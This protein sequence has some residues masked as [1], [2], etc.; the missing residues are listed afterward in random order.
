MTRGRQTNE[1]F[2]YQPVT[3]E[4]DHQHTPPITDP[5][6]HLL[7]RGNTY[8]AAHHFRHILGHDDRPRTLPDHAQRTPPEHLPAEVADLLSRNA[9]RRT[10][11][12]EVWR[13][14]S[15]GPGRSAPATSRL[16]TSSAA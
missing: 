14:T 4:A 1:A 16:L 8:S 7:R 9:T 11:R 2:L 15:T 12:H 5:E 13:E 6:T 10:A 3:G